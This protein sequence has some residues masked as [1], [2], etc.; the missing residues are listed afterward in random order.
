MK[1][2]RETKAKAKRFNL[3]LAFM[4]DLVSV[5]PK[6]VREKFKGPEINPEKFGT[7]ERRLRFRKGNLVARK[8]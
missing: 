6:I 1:E 7:A 2:S 8:I 3:L 4:V 5:R